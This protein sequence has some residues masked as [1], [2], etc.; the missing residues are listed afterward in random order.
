MQASL[1]KRARTFHDNGPANQAAAPEV[2]RSSRVGA[3]PH[4][5]VDAAVPVIHVTAEWWGESLSQAS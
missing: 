5:S 1:C 2:A 3:F 4:G